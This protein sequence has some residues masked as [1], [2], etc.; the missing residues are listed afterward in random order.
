M[1]NQITDTSVYVVLAMQEDYISVYVN[2]KR[3]QGRS[4]RRWLSDVVRVPVR[5]T[6][7]VSDVLEAAAGQLRLPPSARWQP[8]LPGL[9]S[10]GGRW[11]AN[12]QP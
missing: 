12:P 6:Q 7:T 1:V 4:S 11:G 5:S 8:P 10:P 3:G 9:G 2:H